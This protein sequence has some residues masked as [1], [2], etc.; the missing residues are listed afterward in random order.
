MGSKGST[1][2]GSTEHVS[3]GPRSHFLSSP[4]HT[5]R[6]HTSSPHSTLIQKQESGALSTTVQ[7][8]S[9]IS[10]ILEQLTV[11]CAGLLDSTFKVQC[12]LK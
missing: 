9:G 2:R 12:A 5:M 6:R 1:Q 4:P 11:G 10:G 3:L 7:S 8:T